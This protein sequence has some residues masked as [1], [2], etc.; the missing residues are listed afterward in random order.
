MYREMQYFFQILFCF[1]FIFFC[2]NYIHIAILTISLIYIYIYKHKDTKDNCN[3][4]VRRLRVFIYPR[5]ANCELSYNH[6]KSK[7][8]LS[9]REAI[10]NSEEMYENPHPQD[11][12][13]CE[14]NHRISFA[15]IKGMRSD[16]SQATIGKV[17]KPSFFDIIIHIS[18]KNFDLFYF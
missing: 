2:F 6:R 16:S 4:I 7:S 3:C 15:S 5:V 10:L 8:F 12:S 13:R 18:V 14:D 17:L 1:L 11:I 9:E